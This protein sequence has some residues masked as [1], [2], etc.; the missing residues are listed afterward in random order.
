MHILLEWTRAPLLTN[1]YY[2][3]SEEERDDRAWKIA[4]YE[5]LV[6]DPQIRST[7][8]SVAEDAHN[9]TT[10]LSGADLHAA[11]RYLK[12][13]ILRMTVPEIAALRPY[14][15]ASLWAR[16]ILGAWR[17]R[18]NPTNARSAKKRARK[19]TVLD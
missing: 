13:C 1:S 17:Y 2:M 5:D 7:A 14:E 8:F 11:R 15:A 9:G 10:P 12:A 3:T 6:A 18:Q 16:G 19:S 4:V